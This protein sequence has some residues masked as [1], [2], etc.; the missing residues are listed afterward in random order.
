[1]LVDSGFNGTEAVNKL[2]GLGQRFLM[3]AIKHKRVKRAIEDYDKK[4]TSAVIDYTI[5][6]A[7]SKRASCCLFM[8]MKKDARLLMRWLIVMW[9]FSRTR[10][11]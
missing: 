5:G 9:R 10:Q 3:P 1:L 4:L 7:E 8:I 11:F 2:K 6:G